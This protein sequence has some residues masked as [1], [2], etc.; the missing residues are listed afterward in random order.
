MFKKEDIPYIEK[1][2]DRYERICDALDAYG[3]I[4]RGD[5]GDMAVVFTV[6]NFKTGTKTTFGCHNLEDIDKNAVIKRITNIMIT[7]AYSIQYLL[8]HKYG[9][10]CKKYE[11]VFQNMSWESGD[12]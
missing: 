5:D 8:W 7:E 12:F 3:K 9:F 10:K 4:Q 1:E 11:D 6:M 2:N